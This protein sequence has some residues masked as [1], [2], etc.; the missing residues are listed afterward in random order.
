MASFPSLLF[1]MTESRHF[2][3]LCSASDCLLPSR[4]YTIHSL[5]SLTD[6]MGFLLSSSCIGQFVNHLSPVTSAVQSIL[7]S[8]MLS[9][10][11]WGLQ[12][13][14]ASPW[15]RAPSE[16]TNRAWRF[17]LAP[18]PVPFSFS[19]SCTAC[20]SKGNWEG[21]KGHKGIQNINIQ[22]MHSFRFDL[23]DL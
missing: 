14:H 17:L 16:V 5:C 21:K 10:A 19:V 3:L 20:E 23:C 12:L 22:M 8:W 2:C 18:E 6:Q 1:P 11:T 15:L 4:L 13:S 9:P 7:D